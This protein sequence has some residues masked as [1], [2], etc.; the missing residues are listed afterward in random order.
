[1]SRSLLKEEPSALAR[2]AI[3]NAWGALVYV[4]GDTGAKRAAVVALIATPWTRGLVKRIGTRHLAVAISATDA[5]PYLG[6]ISPPLRHTVSEPWRADLTYLGGGE[7]CFWRGV[8]VGV[9]IFAMIS[10]VD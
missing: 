3:K 2:F 8:L 9:R 7:S 5:R 1:M 6:P 10:P 4:D